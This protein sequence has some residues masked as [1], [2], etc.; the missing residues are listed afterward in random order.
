[1]AVERLEG[2]LMDL[3]RALKGTSPER[4]ASLGASLLAL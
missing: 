1:M 4:P 2:L 3:K